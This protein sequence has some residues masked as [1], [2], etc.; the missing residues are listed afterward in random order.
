MKRRMYF[1]K[2]GRRTRAWFAGIDSDVKENLED[3][4]LTSLR[5]QSGADK[6]SPIMVIVK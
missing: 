1:I 4:G 5:K 2:N 6:D 3:I